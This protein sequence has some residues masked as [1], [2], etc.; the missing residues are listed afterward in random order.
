MTNDNNFSII[1]II[2]FVMLFIITGYN[3]WRQ[4]QHISALDRLS[5]EL[6]QES[7]IPAHD[8][9]MDRDD[10][11]YEGCVTL[12]EHQYDFVRGKGR[13]GTQHQDIDGDEE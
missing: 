5:R 10:A 1:I 8:L 13:F 6:D 9:E 3:L 7:D 11:L 12:I 4:M 2:S